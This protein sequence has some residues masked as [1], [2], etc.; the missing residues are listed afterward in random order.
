MLQLST[1][2]KFEF[3]TSSD[4]SLVSD[5]V[6][7]CYGLL[8]I[9]SILQ[10]VDLFFNLL[11]KICQIILKPL[12][13][14]IMII[15]WP[16]SSQTETQKSHPVALA[17]IQA[18][19]TFWKATHSTGSW[20]FSESMMAYKSSPRAQDG[21]LQ[22][23]STYLIDVYMWNVYKYR[24]C[25]D[26]G[27]FILFFICGLLIV[28]VEVFELIFRIFLGQISACG[29]MLFRRSSL[30]TFS[31]FSLRPGFNNSPGY[32]CNTSEVYGQSK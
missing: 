16:K 6:F 7:S 27:S 14:T 12:F 17:A 26:I 10:F 1:S 32:F 8:Q 24:I 22:R 29:S 23:W 21:W 25:I 18:T 9:R 15:M 4:Q 30:L 11:K 31:S 19:V 13:S 3:Q 20:R 5:S 28:I 2:R